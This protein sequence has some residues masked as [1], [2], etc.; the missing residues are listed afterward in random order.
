S[1]SSSIPLRTEP[2]PITRT[3]TRTRTTKNFSAAAQGINRTWKTTNTKTNRFPKRST[4]P[5]AAGNP[6][7]PPPLPRS[8]S[9]QAKSRQR[10]RRRQRKT[11]EQS[12]IHHASRITHPYAHQR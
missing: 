11:T 4:L 6:P 5:A 12:E 1:S 9:P 2:G 7:P 8:V 3:R 10:Q